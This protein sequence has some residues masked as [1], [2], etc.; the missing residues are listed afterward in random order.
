M[1]A[2]APKDVLSV[3][4]ESDM[5]EIEIN[6]NSGGG[7]VYA[8]MEIYTALKEHKGKVT[9]KIVG[10]AASAASIIAMAA[11]SIKISPVGQIMIHKASVVASGNHNT[12]DHVSDVL[13]SH[14]EGIANAYMLKTGKSKKEILEF[15]DKETYFSAKTAIEL[16][17]ADEIMFDNDMQLSASVQGDIP[18]NIIDKI[19]NLLIKNELPASDEGAFLLPK[20]ENGV[21]NPQ[22]ISNIDPVLQAQQEQFKNLKL[23]IMGGMLK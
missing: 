6:I 15:M 4:R 11:E 3:L 23:K 21:D 2:T 1:D 16:G 20:I 12:M 5:E 14:D 17:F 7:N 18:Q 19:K 22:P 8:G 13:Q 10:L 9:C